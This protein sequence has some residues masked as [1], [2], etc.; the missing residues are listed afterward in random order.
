M[1]QR[2]M[3]SKKVH[4]AGWTQAVVH[5]SGWRM[6]LMGCPFDGNDCDD[7]CDDDCDG[8]ASTSAAIPSSPYRTSL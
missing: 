8:A 2:D 6:A 4:I 5:A 1:Q 7:D 3:T